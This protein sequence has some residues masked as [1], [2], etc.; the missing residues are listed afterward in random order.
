M[1]YGASTGTLLPQKWV[2]LRGK[3]A[4]TVTKDKLLNGFILTKELL[5]TD[6]RVGGVE[7]TPPLRATVVMLLLNYLQHSPAIIYRAWGVNLNVASLTVA[8]MLLY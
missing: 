4:I 1:E 2:D 6:H 8:P 7:A 3:G 5:Y